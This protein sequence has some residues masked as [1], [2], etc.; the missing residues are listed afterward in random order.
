[1][2]KTI[3]YLILI[4]AGIIFLYPFL[5]MISSSFKPEFEISGLGLTSENF[6]FDNYREVCTTVPMGRAFLNSLFV[7]TT[8]TCSVILFG[9]IVG[10][11]LS[12]IN[13]TG[14]SIILAVILMTM[15]LPF[16]ITMIP[17]Y[18]L[19]V[20]LGWIDTYMALIVPAMMN[21]LSILLLR[22]FFMNIP[23]ELLEAARI[24]G[25][26]NMQ[27]LFRIM[28]PLSVPVIVTVGLLSFMA[29]WNDILWP[30]IVIRAREM[31]TIP[32]TVTLFTVGG[33]AEQT[34]MKLAAA[35]LL[36]LPMLVLY[37]FFQKYFIES[38]ASSGL[39]G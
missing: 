19:M 15:I 9:S 29:S 39:K 26:G 33:Q 30:I 6:S 31:I 11:A 37:A 3:I 4:T 5:W 38:M 13:F 17:L 36:A 12:R 20:K 28:Y 21:P 18:I 14:R 2:K 7:S 24:D 35:T 22:Q 27:I 32:Q 23:N 25:C 8:V 34:G 10:Y 1:M 16:Q